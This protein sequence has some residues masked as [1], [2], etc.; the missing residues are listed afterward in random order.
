MLISVNDVIIKYSGTKSV[1][2]I[3]GWNLFVPGIRIGAHDFKRFNKVYAYVALPKSDIWVFL[4]TAILLEVIGLDKQYYVIVHDVDKSVKH[5]W[6]VPKGQVEYKEFLEIKSQFRSP[7]TGLYGLLKEG[8]ARE[9][10]EEAKISLDD[11]IDLR[12]VPDLVVAG[13]HK[14]LPNHFHYQYHIFEG[15]IHYSFFEKAKKELDRLRMN[16]TL[17]L[18]MSKDMIEKD[19]IMLW[20]PSKGL[21]NIIEGDPQKIVNLYMA[22]KNI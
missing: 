11:V 10:E 2:K 19:N 22:Y 7:L 5:G 15:K 9:L 16:P 17:T 3:Y 4:R 6:D 13:K 18:D 14:D 8:I 21:S 12:L 20:S 1:S